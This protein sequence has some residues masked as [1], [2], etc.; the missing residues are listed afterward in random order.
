[1]YQRHGG[2]SSRNVGSTHSGEAR[3]IR[4]SDMGGSPASNSTRKKAAEAVSPS[5]YPGSS[6][7]SLGDPQSEIDEKIDNLKDEYS[8]IA[9]DGRGDTVFKFVEGLRVEYDKAKATNNSVIIHSTKEHLLA[10]L[11]EQRDYIMEDIDS[12]LKLGNGM[13]ADQA[14]HALQASNFLFWAACE[15]KRMDPQDR[16]NILSQATLLVTAVS[17]GIRDFKAGISGIEPNNRLVRAFKYTEN[18]IFSPIA[19]SMIEGQQ[20]IEGKRGKTIKMNQVD[21]SH[22]QGLPVNTINAQGDCVQS[23]EIPV[24]RPTEQEFFGKLYRLED[25]KARIATAG[26]PDL[27]PILYDSRGRFHSPAQQHLGSPRSSATPRSIT[28]PRRSPSGPKL[29]RASSLPSS[30]N[31]SRTTSSTRS[32]ATLRSMTPPKGSSLK[33]SPS[34]PKLRR[35]ASPPSGFESPRTTPAHKPISSVPLTELTQLQE[36]FSQRCEDI[37]NWA[38]ERCDQALAEVREA[39]SEPSEQ[40]IQQIQ[41][42]AEASIQH[43]QEEAQS[44]IDNEYETLAQRLAMDRDSM[45]TGDQTATEEISATLT[46]KVTHVKDQIDAKIKATI[47]TVK[48]QCVNAWLK[49]IDKEIAEFVGNELLQIDNVQVGLSAS[50]E[51]TPTSY[52]IDYKAVV[53]SCKAQLA[54]LMTARRNFV[55]TLTKKAE[56]N[57]GNTGFRDY[58]ASEFVESNADLAKTIAK[59][60]E[61]ESLINATNVPLPAPVDSLADNAEEEGGIG[62]ANVDSLAQDIDKLQKKQARKLR[63]M[64]EK[65]IALKRSKTNVGKSLRAWMSFVTKK[66]KSRKTVQKARVMLSQRQLSLMFEIWKEFWSSSEVD[67]AEMQAQLQSGNRE[68]VAKSFLEWAE[69]TIKAKTITGIMSKLPKNQHIKVLGNVLE[70][71][72]AAAVGA[73]AQASAQAQALPQ[74]QVRAATL[75][76]SRFRGKKAREKILTDLEAEVG[77]AELRQSAATLIQSRF[78]GNNARKKILKDL[79]ADEIKKIVEADLSMISGSNTDHLQA[80]L[81]YYGLPANTTVDEFNSTLTK[82][83]ELTEDL[84]KVPLSNELSVEENMQRLLG[85]VRAA[86]RHEENAAIAIQSRFRRNNARKN[87]LTEQADVGISAVNAELREISATFIQSRFRKRKTRKEQEALREMHRATKTPIQKERF[88]SNRVTKLIEDLRSNE[89]TLEQDIE[90]IEE[91]Q[92]ML[93]WR[94]TNGGLV[95]S[96][97]KEVRRVVN[98]FAKELGCDVKDKKLKKMVMPMILEKIQKREKNPPIIE[99]QPAPE[100]ATSAVPKAKAAASSPSAATAAEPDSIAAEDFFDRV[101]TADSWEAIE[102]LIDQLHEKDNKYQL[103][104]GEKYNQATSHFFEL[105]LQYPDKFRATYH[106][107]KTKIANVW[108]STEAKGF[109]DRLSVSEDNA[110]LITQIKGELKGIHVNNGMAILTAENLKDDREVNRLLGIEGEGTLEDC[111]R[112]LA[113]TNKYKLPQDSKFLD[114]IKAK[115]GNKV[116]KDNLEYYVTTGELKDDASEEL[117]E[118]VRGSES[119]AVVQKREQF[120]QQLAIPYE[121]ERIKKETS[122]ASLAELA[123]T[124]ECSKAAKNAEIQAIKTHNTKEYTRL[125]DS[126]HIKRSFESCKQSLKEGK[127]IFNQT[128]ALIEYFSAEG[129]QVPD[130]SGLLHRGGFGTVDEPLTLLKETDVTQEITATFDG[131]QVMDKLASEVEY[132]KIGDNTLPCYTNERGEKFICLAK[133]ELKQD[134][135]VSTIYDGRDE[136]GQLDCQTDKVG[137]LEKLT[138]AQIKKLRE[139]NIDVK[140]VR[141]IKLEQGQSENPK[142]IRILGEGIAEEVEIFLAISDEEEQVLLSEEVGII[143]TVQYELTLPDDLIMQ[144]VDAEIQALLAPL[145]KNRSYKERASNET[146][147]WVIPLEEAQKKLAS[148]TLAEIPGVQQAESGRCLW[149]D[150][151]CWMASALSCHATVALIADAV[152]AQDAEV[153]AAAVSSPDSTARLGAS[154][155][156]PTAT[157]QVTPS[158]VVPFAAALKAKAAASSAPAATASESSEDV[159]LEE[160]QKQVDDEAKIAEVKQTQQK[161]LE[162]RKLKLIKLDNTE[163]KVGNGFNTLGDLLGKVFKYNSSKEEVVVRV[164]EIHGD[165]EVTLV[166]PDGRE[167]KTSL[168]VKKIFGRNQ[169]RILESTPEQE[170]LFNEQEESCKRESVKAHLNEKMSRDQICTI[171]M[172]SQEIDSKDDLD[173]KLQEVARK[174]NCNIDLV[175][176]EVKERVQIIAGRILFR[177]KAKDFKSTTEFYIKN[178]LSEQLVLHEGHIAHTRLVANMRAL[179]VKEQNAKMRIAKLKN[180]IDQNKMY[181]V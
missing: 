28:P 26:S 99:Q 41:G 153:A 142:V 172:D 60:E 44:A 155:L 83:K 179:G 52:T 61:I 17:D 23:S 180:L 67:K 163:K 86:D 94:Y 59:I 140:K 16:S 12:I 108:C 111:A 32:T 58:I 9:A 63:E 112:A 92:A 1:M 19:K 46:R 162:Y 84:E 29:G 141:K 98:A 130:G 168:V 91:I 118:Y 123:I 82:L 138:E 169:S 167:E 176:E 15:N 65:R 96:K 104:S 119:E 42:T 48:V 152:Q 40:D 127:P 36:T 134:H 11:D 154:S 122:L 73:K 133:A 20:R 115:L 114:E 74:E 106:T 5:M 77:G 128:M 161:K 7:S 54:E 170:K 156:P 6:R 39:L 33:L 66:Q 129:I 132:M 135:W 157:A 151:N 107:H 50:L 4:G 10:S 90:K 49:H 88:D 100:S 93:E 55:E 126:G 70:V 57:R 145:N 14:A 21:L 175:K 174:Y 68:S 109:F 166:Y 75:I 81:E 24:V 27:D 178:H 97:N 85:I 78:R 51:G 47:E 120:L 43:I 105:A 137:E 113:K 144:E 148:L 34:R 37:R 30:V 18:V 110:Y 71:W 171:I 35:T 150:N 117:K 131:F 95:L 165:K 38:F 56:Q 158:A 79:Q 181:F 116:D 143:D 159:N 69:K 173:A 8:T 31:S 136:K 103:E 164:S 102:S 22:L 13:G 72:N 101:A 160:L 45:P 87:F 139:N 80:L 62:L 149:A 25:N 125:R 146:K 3:Y 64:K 177:N 89:G 53:S 121:I 147:L 124:K 2:E 76:Q